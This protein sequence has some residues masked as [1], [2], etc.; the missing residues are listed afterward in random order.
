[1]PKPL[2][3]RRPSGFYVR[4]YVPARWRA[5]LGLGRYL[6]RSLA[7][8]DADSARLEA[9]RLGYALGQ[10]FS[11]AKQGAGVSFTKSKDEL[12]DYLRSLRRLEVTTPEGYHFKTD[13]SEHEARELRHMLADLR[14]N[15]A[16]QSYAVAPPPPAPESSKP[17]LSER[18]DLFL[19]QFKARKVSAGNVLDTAYTLRLLLG[20]VGDKPLAEV[21]APDMDILMDALANLPPNASKDRVLRDLSPQ[22]VIAKAKREGIEPIAFRTREKHL[23]RLRAFF[24]WA[25]EREDIKRNPAASLHFLSREQEETRDRRAFTPEE[26]AIIFDPDRRAEHCT[27]PAQWWCPLVALFTGARVAEVALLRVSD[28]VQVDGAYGFQFHWKVKNANSR[29]FVPLH[30]ELLRVGITEYRRL[31]EQALGPE[32]PLFPSLSADPVDALG[33]WFNRTYLRKVCGLTDPK[34]VYYCFRHTFATLADRAGIIDARIAEIT[35]HSARGSILRWHYIDPGTVRQKCETLR[36]VQPS[37]P[38]SAHYP[39]ALFVDYLNTYPKALKRARSMAA[40]RVAKKQ[41]PAK[42]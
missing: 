39:K 10:W 30:I 9:A 26:L 41:K 25:I 29:R 21:A 20:L 28:L 31:V 24:N 8:F 12:D 4:F 11:A 3:L 16:A 33:D 13:G 15:R 37:M 22:E 32:A 5:S 23:D 40:K 1:M 14:A 36:A 34:L 2:L 19:T 7:G 35:G 27:T 18:I 42:G 38:P 6:V 17:L